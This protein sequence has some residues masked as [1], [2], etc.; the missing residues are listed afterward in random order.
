MTLYSKKIMVR[1]AVAIPTYHL[2]Y[3]FLERILTNI[4]EQI[5]L[6][7]LVSISASSCRTEEEKKTLASIRSRPWPFRLIL[8]EFEAIAFTAENRNR[9][10]AAAI[11]A[12]ADI[13]SFFDCDDLMHPRR[14]QRL[15]AVFRNHSDIDC[16]LHCFDTS[17]SFKG[18]EENLDLAV[19][20]GAA[21]LKSETRYSP[22]TK[23]HIVLQRLCIED[24]EGITYGHVTVRA[25]CFD[26][27]LQNTEALGYE[28]SLY[29]TDLLKA[30][31]NVACIPYRLSIYS[32]V[33]GETMD[34]NKE[35][36]LHHLSSLGSH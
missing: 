10:A 6:P 5:L 15:E 4:S 19:I 25:H 12:G 32:L 17:D 18:F 14:I 9:A 31:Y 34:K 20:K 35:S 2:H 30:N 21:Y 33:D 8:Q 3:C 24:V 29:L 11:D 22:F 27:V 26:K 7:D 1:F 36:M 13:I 16:I 28:D 23:S